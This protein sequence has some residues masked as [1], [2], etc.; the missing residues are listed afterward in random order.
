[1]GYT[2]AMVKDMVLKNISDSNLRTEH[3]D[4]C[5]RQ[6][7][8]WISNTPGAA[9]KLGLDSKTAIRLVNQAKMG[10]PLDQLRSTIKNS[11]G[12]YSKLFTWHHNPRNGNGMDFV[13]SSKHAAN[14]H[15]GGLSTFWKQT[16]KFWQN[17]LKRR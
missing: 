7:A 6:F 17:R 5:N 9:R 14:S 15:T 10:R 11:D 3:F 16:S 12:T 2:N 4:I 8:D 1:M 13:S